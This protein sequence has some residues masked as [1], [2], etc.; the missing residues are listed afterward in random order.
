MDKYCYSVKRLSKLYPNN[1]FIWEFETNPD[2]TRQIYKYDQIIREVMVCLDIFRREK[3]KSFTGISLDVRGHSARSCILLLSILNHGCHFYCI[4][5]KT[6][7]NISQKLK[8]SGAEYVISKH[9]QNMDEICTTYATF[10]VLNHTYFI[11]TLPTSQTSITSKRNICYTICT[12]G[13][14]GEPKMIHVPY[15]CIYPN[16]KSLCSLLKINEQDVIFLGSPPT[17]DPFVVEFFMALEMGSSLV[18]A[19][20]TAIRFTN[21]VQLLENITILQTTPSLFRLL[22]IQTIR[23]FVFQTT[24]SLRCLL[25]GGEKFPSPQE[26]QSWLPENFQHDSK[27][28]FNIYGITEYS[29]WATIH[30]YQPTVS[31]K[32]IE[33]RIPLGT[34]LDE[35]T[36]LHINNDEGGDKESL[37]GV[38]KGELLIGSS[39]RR[40]FIPQCDKDNDNDANEIIFRKTGDL[41]ERDE[42]GQLF[43]IGRINNCIKRLGKRICLDSLASKI[44]NL[45]KTQAICLWD[46]H[47]TKLIFCL[48]CDKE[49]KGNQSDTQNLFKTHLEDFEQPDQIEY[50]EHMPLN[51]HGKVDNKK[52]LSKILENPANYKKTPLSVFQ[53]FLEQVMGFQQ[54]PVTTTQINEEATNAKRIKRNLDVGFLQAGGTSFQALSLATEIG[55]LMYRP[56]EQR[57]FLEML[58]S[59]EVSLIDVMEFLENA[60]PNEQ[61][62]REYKI[63]LQSLTSLNADYKIKFLWRSD[64][65]K[66]VDASPTI[67]ENEYVAVGSHSHILKTLNTTTG[68]EITHLELSDRIE[69]PVVFVS[70]NMALVGCYDGLLYGFNFNTSEILWQISV[71]G[72]IKAKPVIMDGRIILGSYGEDYNVYAFDLRSLNCLWKLKLGSKGIFSSPLWLSDTLVLFCSLDGSYAS[73]DIANGSIKWKKK[74]DS[75]IFSTPALVKNPRIEVV[76]AEVRGRVI[77]CSAENGKEITHFQADGNIFSSITLLQKDSLQSTFILFGCHDGNLYCLKYDAPQSQILLHWKFALNSAVYSTPALA[78]DKSIVVACSIKGQLVLV[79]TSQGQIKGSYDFKAEIFSSPCVSDSNCIYVGARDNFLYALQVL[80]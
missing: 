49:D 19:T 24:S 42:G 53:N 38:C 37:N 51:Q 32:Y 39:I 71:N 4:D 64:L 73:I 23:D 30:E 44:E 11:G 9:I 20:N 25:L 50:V 14:T 58:L 33:N 28:I 62:T 80:Q 1:P 54:A 63:D 75:P 74:L 57:Q 17:F 10:K 12:S 69:C 46:E 60:K 45:S 2:L 79:D 16:I 35:A 26:I 43:Y 8:D 72:M 3:I 66:C 34:P 21:S 78:F 56:E 7:N 68:S 65:K 59:S 48:H 29:C 61:T 31:S 52:L 47:H 5:F 22:G 27:R 41:V 67:F 76:L 18:V 13:S 77:I 36:I 40:C 15:E 70:S 6:T 55:E